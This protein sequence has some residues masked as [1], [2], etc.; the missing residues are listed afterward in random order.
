MTLSK[1]KDNRC[2]ACGSNDLLLARDKTAYSELEVQDGKLVAA[3][4]HEEWSEADDAVRVYCAK[5]GEY[6]EVPDHL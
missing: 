1:L 6:F 3:Y 5:C 4:S 2:S